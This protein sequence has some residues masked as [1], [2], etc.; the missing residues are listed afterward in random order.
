M[1]IKLFYAFFVCGAFQC[2]EP[3]AMCPDQKATKAA[4]VRV[5][6]YNQPL[7]SQYKIK[8]AQQEARVEQLYDKEVLLRA[9]LQDAGM[10]YENL[11]ALNKQSL[12]E[13]QK[14]VRLWALFSDLKRIGNIIHN[15]ESAIKNTE[16]AIRA[17]EFEKSLANYLKALQV[18][19]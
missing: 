11:L 15:E 10:C 13:L 12:R 5:K 8:L 9:H 18:N 4:S 19:P 1:K 6:K 14:N 17:L 16:N 7:I 3:P 2:S